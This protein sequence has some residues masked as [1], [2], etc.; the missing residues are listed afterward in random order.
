MD[1]VGELVTCICTVNLGMGQGTLPPLLP[2]EW[3]PRGSKCESVARL[4]PTRGSTAPSLP[5][6]QRHC[7]RELEEL[8]TPARALC[9]ATI[10]Y[11]TA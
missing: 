10:Q 7:A 3:A 1:R 9:A 4:A 11:E 8:K 2:L 5:K 6:T